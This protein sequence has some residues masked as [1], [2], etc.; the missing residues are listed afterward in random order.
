MQWSD[1]QN[2]VSPIAP[3]RLV[4]PRYKHEYDMSVNVAAQQRD[5]GSLLN[6]LERMTRLRMRSPE[7][8][9]SRCEWLETSHSAVLAHGCLGERSC[10][11]AIHNLSRRELDVTVKLARKVEGLFDVLN[12]CDS[13]VAEDG[14]QRIHLKPYGYLWLREGR[15]LEN[16]VSA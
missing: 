7:F 2:A 12:N 9:V 4:L 3:E 6:R 15:G 10:V 11:F 13:P 1:A 16:L 5:P 8:G 14:C